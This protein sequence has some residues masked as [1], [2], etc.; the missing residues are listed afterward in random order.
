[1]QTL[2]LTKAMAL[3]D[4]PVF[5]QQYVSFMTCLRARSVS[6]D[7]FCHQAEAKQLSAFLVPCL[8]FRAFHA[9]RFHS[10]PLGG[11]TR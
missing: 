10:C 6:L 1:V 4:F 5:A 9:Q 2:N 3:P 8:A 7:E 11:T